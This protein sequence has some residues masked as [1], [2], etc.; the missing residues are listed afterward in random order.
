MET[1]KLVNQ[2]SKERGRPCLW[3]SAAKDVDYVRRNPSRG[4]TRAQ[5]L[6]AMRAA[7]LKEFHPSTKDLEDLS[8]MGAIPCPATI[9]RHFG[10]VKAALAALKRR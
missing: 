4:Y 7:G 2:V 3:M 6:R 5:I 1:Q 9:I 8:D 10:S